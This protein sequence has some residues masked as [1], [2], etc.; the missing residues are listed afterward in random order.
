[1]TAAPDRPEFDGTSPSL[2]HDLPSCSSSASAGSVESDALT[3]ATATA[4]TTPWLSESSTVGCWKPRQSAAV[5]KVRHDDDAGS[6][7]CCFQRSASGAGREVASPQWSIDPNVVVALPVA[8]GQ[9]E[10]PD[11]VRPVPSA[12]EGSVLDYAAGDD[13]ADGAA[14]QGHRGVRCGYSVVSGS[15]APTTI[16]VDH[17]ADLDSLARNFEAWLGSAV[18]A[19]EQRLRMVSLAATKLE[20]MQRG[21]ASGAQQLGAPEEPLQQP[22][23]AADVTGRGAFCGGVGSCAVR[24]DPEAET[25]LGFDWL[26]KELRLHVERAVETFE[27]KLRESAAQLHEERWGAL[28]GVEPHLAV[29]AR[30]GPCKL[31]SKGAGTY[32]GG[33]VSVPETSHAL[34]LAAEQSFSFTESFPS[35]LLGPQVP[36]LRSTARP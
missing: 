33:P 31:R 28:V 13:P 11:E 8:D 21:Q 23:A 17:G 14:G 7:A 18:E 26:A 16:P 35:V 4:L 2:A 5:E 27:A 3:A 10:L 15:A 25:A 34:K 30:G 22:Q 24:R 32:C 20:P 12:V 19:A 1:M 29:Q 36:A 6:R 9:C